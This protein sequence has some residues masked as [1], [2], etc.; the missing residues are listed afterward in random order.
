[1][2]LKL[3]GWLRKRPRLGRLA[4]KCLPDAPL[5]IQI[6]PIGPFRIRLRRNRSYWL[7]SPVIGEAFF[8]GVFQRLLQPGDVF[9]DIGA[10]LGLYVRFLIQ[11]FDAGRVVAFEPMSDT[12]ALLEANVAKD[13]KV[14]ARTTLFKVAVGDV[15]SVEKFQVDDMSSA[16]STLDRVSGG[17]ASQGRLQ[18]GLPPRF[19]IVQVMPLDTVIERNHLPPPQLIKIDIEGA[20]PLALAGMRRTLQTHRPDLVIETHGTEEARAVLLALQSHGYHCFG[21]V[22]RDGSRGYFEL[23]ES[24]VKPVGDFYQPHHLVASTQ[25]EKLRDEIN[26]HHCWISQAS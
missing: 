20:A 4:L 24:D 26:P 22:E 11:Q 25:P 3:A 16:S 1:L 13:P 18:Y 6:P 5:T 17:A 15:E 23:A 14:A 12:F 7:R 9:Y 8:F 2:I 10:N 21:F 19:E